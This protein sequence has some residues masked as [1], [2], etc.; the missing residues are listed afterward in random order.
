M[1]YSIVG[2]NQKFAVRGIDKHVQGELNGAKYLLVLQN[3]FLPL[4]HVNIQRKRLPIAGTLVYD[5]RHL[6]KVF[7]FWTSSLHGIF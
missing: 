6:W 7:R 5:A 2:N 3:K 4:S 1:S